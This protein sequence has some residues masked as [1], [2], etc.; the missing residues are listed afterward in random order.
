[1]NFTFYVKFIISL[2]TLL[3]CNYEKNSSPISLGNFFRVCT[4]TEFLRKTLLQN[5]NSGGYISNSR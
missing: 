2:S 1:M 4:R 3:I 5:V